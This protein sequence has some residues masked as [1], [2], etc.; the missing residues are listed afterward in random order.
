MASGLRLIG[1]LL[2]GGWLLLFA[3]GHLSAYLPPAYFWW[4]GLPASFLPYVGLAALVPLGVHAALRQWGWVAAYGLLLVL[5]LGRMGLPSS[6]AVP[7]SDDTFQLLSLNYTPITERP[8]A[9]PY[10]REVL[11]TLA[12][13]YAPDAIAIQSMQVYRRG[14][15]VRLFHQL[16]TLATLGYAVE[17]Q[18]GAEDHF[19]TRVP[20][21]VRGGG[22]PRQDFIALPSQARDRHIT[23]SEVAWDGATVAIYNAHLH[24]FDRNRLL[25][26]LARD[27]YGA[28][29][30]EFFAMYRRG[31]R[32]RA[33]E[34][35]EL[36]TLVEKDSLPAVVVGDLN[37][38]PFNWEYRH[39]RQVLNDPAARHGANWRATWP[40]DR[41][42]VRIDHVLATPHWRGRG[43]AV[44]PAVISD[45]R[46][47]VVGLQL[48]AP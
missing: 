4:T 10:L 40:A 21:F 3:L 46:A 8:I 15:G 11:G 30:R 36:R 13:T 38:T 47:L 19:D 29:F 14:D 20:L 24:S 28:A 39:L 27:A 17:P 48:K 45:H 34:A 9:Q 23:R 44:D 12:A 37:A 22:A 42:L 43:A 18:T 7:P 35:R 33:H 2:S 31:M 16:D 6:G 25:R 32:Q 5:L 26:L 1:R 41:P